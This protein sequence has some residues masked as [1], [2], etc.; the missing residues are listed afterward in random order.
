[1]STQTARV[2]WNV[3][4]ESWLLDLV[5]FDLNTSNDI[6]GLELDK[7]TN[8]PWVFEGVLTDEHLS[9]HWLGRIYQSGQSYQSVTFH[10]LFSDTDG[11][12]FEGHTVSPELLSQVL[13]SQLPAITPRRNQ[14]FRVVFP[15]HDVDGDL[16][17]GATITAE[18][19]KDEGGYST[20]SDAPVEIGSSGTYAITLTS[21]E[22]DASTVTLK[23]TGV[24]FVARVLMIAT[25][26]S[27]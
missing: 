9:G 3:G 24:G 25:Q 5:P 1:M 19:S 23:L 7:N 2:Y 10:F 20:V 17:S 16:V 13:S 14:A 6:V 21:T 27:A 22:M 8:F 26:P 12:S 18:V 15:L 11:D 4:N